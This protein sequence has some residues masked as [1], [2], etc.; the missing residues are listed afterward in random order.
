MYSEWSYSKTR[1]HFAADS[2]Y[3]TC[4]K[5]CCILC[6]DPFWLQWPRSHESQQHSLSD[7]RFVLALWGGLCR[8]HRAGSRWDSFLHNSS[9]ICGVNAAPFPLCRS[10]M[11]VLYVKQR[12]DPDHSF[13]FSYLKVSRPMWRNLF[14]PW[15]MQIICGEKRW[16][17]KEGEKMRCGNTMRQMRERGSE[18]K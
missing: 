14:N 1:Q 15:E 17:E 4:C 3:C 7:C 10:D 5:I 16:K 8:E 18:R 12:C 13:V 6:N 2:S 11:P 9:S